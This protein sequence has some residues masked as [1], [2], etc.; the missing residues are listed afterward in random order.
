V[1]PDDKYRELFQKIFNEAIGYSPSVRSGS[2]TEAALILLNGLQAL[3]PDLDTVVSGGTAAVQKKIAELNG[4]AFDPRFRIAQQY[5]GTIATNPGGNITAVI[6]KAPPELKEQ[7]YI[8]LAQREINNGDTARARQIINEHVTNPY[9]RQQALANL[10]QQE[11]VRAMNKGKVDEALRAIAGLR[12]PRERA[13]RLA[14]IANQIGPGQKRASA[15]ILLEQARALVSPSPQAQDEDQMRALFE[16][17]RAFARYDVKRAFEI[18]DPLVDQVN[19]LCSAA[20][21]LEG[22][23]PEYYDDD[24]LNL[25]NGNTVGNLA[26]QMSTVLGNLA[27]IN[28]DRAKLASDRIRLPEVRLRAYLEISQHAIQGK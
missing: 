19:D 28:F 23:G 15:L 3:G 25:E 21:T 26:T 10:E 22:F 7:L 11:I 9:Q 27:L 8:Q 13:N 1:L 4:G 20:R 17:A 5:E 18:L 16:I 12:N 6:D 2:E 14:Q 24:E